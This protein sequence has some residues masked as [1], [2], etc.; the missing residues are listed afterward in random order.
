MSKK[1][2]NPRRVK[3][4]RN[5]TVEETARTCNVHKNTVRRWIKEGLQCCDTKR[6]T[7]ILGCALREFLDQKRAKHKRKLKRGEIYCV[8]CR[9]ARNPHG[10]YA[11]LEHFTSKICNISG[12]CPNCDSVIFRSVSLARYQESIGDLD[13]SIPEAL[14]P[15]IKGVAP[16]LN[17][18]FN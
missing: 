10:G 6:P 11:V 17:S 12:I 2:P 15:L 13:V 14:E 4:H 18:D 9:E 8:K 5:Y 16:S 3:T 7:L 1:H